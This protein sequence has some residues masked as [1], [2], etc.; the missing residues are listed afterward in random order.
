M[1]K[2][3][4]AACIT[5]VIEPIIEKHTHSISLILAIL[6]VSFEFY[7]I[8]SLGLFDEEWEFLLL[9]AVFTIALCILIYA[10]VRVSSMAALCSRRAWRR[11]A[12][13]YSRA[14]FGLV[15]PYGHHICRN[16]TYSFSSCLFSG[17]GCSMW[18]LAAWRGTFRIGA[19][20]SNIEW[21]SIHRLAF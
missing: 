12:A 10:S 1:P 9:T 11:V 5:E 18:P 21:P 6:P 7:Y 19:G 2:S 16:F 3:N 15:A 20:R 14:R 4:I 17:Q 13:L 8:N